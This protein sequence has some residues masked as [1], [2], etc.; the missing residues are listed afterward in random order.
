MAGIDGDDGKVARAKAIGET[1]HTAFW[2]KERGGYNLELGVEQVYTSLCGLGQ[3]G[4]PGALRGRPRCPLAEDGS[5][6]RQ[7]AEIDHG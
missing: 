2:A 7:R 3:H 4:P 6:E 5:G 1:L